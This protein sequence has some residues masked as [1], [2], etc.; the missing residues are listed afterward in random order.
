MDPRFLTDVFLFME[1][2]DRGERVPELDAVYQMLKS[3]AGV[4]EAIAGGID[5]S[6][7]LV[8]KAEKLSEGPDEWVFEFGHLPGS[9]NRLRNVA[10]ANG[11]RFE[12]A[13]GVFYNQ[14]VGRALRMSGAEARQVDAGVVYASFHCT[15][16]RRADPDNR[17]YILKHLLDAFTLWGILKD[18]S[19]V[20]CHMDVVLSEGCFTRVAVVEHDP[21]DEESGDRALIRARHLARQPA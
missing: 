19:F 9:Y 11:V 6:R 17:G 15:G 5:K 16:Q 3:T 2:A 7:P 4:Y 12:E 1:H 18:D 21:Q 20:S 13:F 10:L 14:L 8:L